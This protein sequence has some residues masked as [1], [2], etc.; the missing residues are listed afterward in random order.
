[1]NKSKRILTVILF[2]IPLFTIS[3]QGIA[4]DNTGTGDISTGGAV[5]G[6]GFYRI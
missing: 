5:K 6:K 1:M 2:L 3:I 4:E